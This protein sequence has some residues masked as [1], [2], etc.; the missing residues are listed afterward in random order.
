MTDRQ[1]EAGL[2]LANA[3]YDEAMRC[4]VQQEASAWWKFIMILE[5]MQEAGEENCKHISG[6]LGA[7]PKCGEPYKNI[8][9]GKERTD[10]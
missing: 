4:Q 8:E 7:C 3:K 6:G 5:A 1:I 2:K 9:A 10:E